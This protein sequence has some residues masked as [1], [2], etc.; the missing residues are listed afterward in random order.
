MNVKVDH[1][2]FCNF[3]EELLKCVQ[4]YM[5]AMRDDLPA[6]PASDVADDQDLLEIEELG[7]SMPRQCMKGKSN[8]RTRLLWVYGMMIVLTKANR[9]MYHSPQLNAKCNRK[10]ASLN[11][12]VEWSFVDIVDSL[13]KQHNQLIFQQL[14]KEKII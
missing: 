5:I 7:F 14:K 1:R 13:L 2:R 10:P 11:L 4:W 8:L 9:A 12:F 6:F 3:A